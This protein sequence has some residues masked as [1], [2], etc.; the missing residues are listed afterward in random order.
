MHPYSTRPT[1]GQIEAQAALQERRALLG[2]G[3][4]HE[5][6][7]LAYVGDKVR[8][9]DR[10]RGIPVIVEG[11]IAEIGRGEKLTLRLPWQEAVPSIR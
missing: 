6:T 3:Y 5:K 8:W 9:A 7:L 10:T 1:K 2:L 4:V 11:E